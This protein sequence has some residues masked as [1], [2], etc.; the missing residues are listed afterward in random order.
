MDFAGTEPW[1]RTV[2][3]AGVFAG[4]ALT[5]WWVLNLGGSAVRQ[6]LAAAGALAAIPAVIVAPMQDGGALT[7]LALFALAGFLVSAGSAVPALRSRASE[8]PFSPP[9]PAAPAPP[10][11][12]APAPAAVPAARPAT[13]V[14]DH[15]SV[16][17]AHAAPLSEQTV[18][19]GPVAAIDEIA[20]LVDYSAE[21]HPYR[22]AAD[23]RIGRDPA[24]E[25]TLDDDGASREHARIKLEDGRFVLYDLGSTN[26]TRLVREG[27]RR[28]IAA[29]APLH[30]LDVV[31]IGDTRLVFISVERVR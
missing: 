10:A 13:R 8:S 28:K 23:S 9:A 25:I 2:L 18:A 31:E 4:A 22:L 5:A 12:A 15:Q 6:L 3:L 27:R 24:A 19:L 17:R 30:D 21:G 1:L 26:G 11:P 29:P 14:A 7:A 20:F 16:T